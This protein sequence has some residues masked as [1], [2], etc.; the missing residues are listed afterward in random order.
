MSDEPKHGRASHKPVKLGGKITRSRQ[1]QERSIISE[2]LRSPVTDASSNNKQ[3]P[4]SHNEHR[5]Q[6]VS[7]GNKE[8][9]ASGETFVLKMDAATNRLSINGNSRIFE[10]TTWI[11]TTPSYTRLSAS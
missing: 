8:A 7:K 4:R 6:L 9:I 11:Q 3:S 10:R 5:Y 1:A 2:R